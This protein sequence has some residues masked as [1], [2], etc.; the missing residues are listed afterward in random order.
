MKGKNLPK[1]LKLIEGMDSPTADIASPRPLPAVGFLR[2]GFVLG[3][4]YASP[5][6]F[7]SASSLRRMSIE[8]NIIPFS[9]S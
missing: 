9:S 4:F 5:T 8:N 3:S 6:G 1:G 2:N 7:W